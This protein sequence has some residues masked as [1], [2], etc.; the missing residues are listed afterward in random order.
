MGDNSKA[1]DWQ[2]SPAGIDSKEGVRRGKQRKRVKRLVGQKWQA[3]RKV[4]VPYWWPIPM[5]NSGNGSVG[6]P[7]W[8]PSL[9]G[10]QDN[11]K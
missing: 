7:Y 2:P 10:H 3:T 5:G 9:M 6:N 1:P 11:R 8:R 4:R